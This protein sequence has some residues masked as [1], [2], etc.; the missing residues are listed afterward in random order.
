MNQADILNMHSPAKVNLFLAVTGLRAD[1]FH[2]LLSLAVP[3]AFGDR[4]GIRRLATGSADVLVCPTAGV[5]LDNSNLILKAAE[6][7]RAAAGVEAFFH[8]ELDKRIPMGAGL[9][10]GSGNAAVALLAMNRLCGEP[11][12]AA[13]LAELCGRLGS[14]CPFFL[15]PRPRLM[16]GRGELLEAI[17]ENACVA[18]KQR[19][20]LLFKPSFSVATPWAYGALRES[21][22]RDYIDSSTAS[23]MLGAWL[24]N[25]D[26]DCLPLVNNLQQPVFRKYLALP[27][28][29]ERLGRRP[30]VRCM[31]S[32]SGSACF[33]CYKDPTV[34]DDLKADIREAL[35]ESVWIMDTNI[36]DDA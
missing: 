11:L 26:F 10:G 28:L 23:A 35:G 27:V 25:P 13:A 4:L 31:M 19:P 15:Q 33:C 6:A 30:G 14:D 22:G 1:G 12:K 3:L 20:L 21:G 16:R 5:P 36:T 8:F 34:V 2:E 9:G 24:R 29:L 17:P 32:G 18:L 7:F